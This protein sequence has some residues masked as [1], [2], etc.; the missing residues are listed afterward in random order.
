MI[1]WAAVPDPVVAAGDPGNTVVPDP[2]SHALMTA[3]TAVADLQ[4]LVDWKLYG[5]LGNLSGSRLN[6]HERVVA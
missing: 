4:L 1:A 5:D 3:R 6:R 2:R